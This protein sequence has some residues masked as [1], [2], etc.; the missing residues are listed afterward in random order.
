[1]NSHK[2]AVFLLCRY[3]SLY[4]AGVFPTPVGLL[5]ARVWIKLKRSAVSK[6]K[7]MRILGLWLVLEVGHDLLCFPV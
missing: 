2:S 3:I 6:N 4:G 7:E 1:M 5:L